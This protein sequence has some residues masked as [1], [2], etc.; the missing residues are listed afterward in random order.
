L[1]GADMRRADLR[2]CWLGCANLG[3]ANL[4]G[5]DL[6]GSDLRSATLTG[7]DLRGCNLRRVKFAGQ[8]AIVADSW[9][10]EARLDGAEVAGAVFDAGTVWPTGYDPARHGAVRCAR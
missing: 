7:A 4:Q 6:S 9:I 8:D 3:H 5:A 2:D 10:P 1:T